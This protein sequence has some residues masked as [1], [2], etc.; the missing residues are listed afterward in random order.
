MSKKTLMTIGLLSAACMTMQ[1][2]SQNEEGKFNF[3]MGG[4]LSV[5]LNPAA[6]YVGVGGSFLGGGGYNIDQHS[7]IMGQ[8]QWDG[9]PP[10]VGAI[11][12]LN[13][14]S[15]SVN[16]YGITAEYKYRSGIG[17][18]FGFYVITGG[19]WYYRHASISKSTFVPTDTVCQPIYSWYGYTCS[20]GFVNTVGVGAGTS[21]F[22]GNGGIGLTIRVKDS[23]WKFFVESRYTYAMSRAI[24]TQVAPV[25]FGFE[26]Q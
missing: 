19:G 16:L 6:R 11:A 3:S 22:G 8:F 17:K 20:N 21:S 23:G 9:L 26:Y 4:G 14:I 18:T 24:A 12:Q 25:T 7:S 1:A 5:P 10:S 15:Q 2:Q 13:G